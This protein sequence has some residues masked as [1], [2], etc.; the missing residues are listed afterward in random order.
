MRR[1]SRLRSRSVRA[2]GHEGRQLAP[3]ARELAL[4]LPER[5][6]TGSAH[7]GELD[8]GDAVADQPEQP[9][10]L[11]LVSPTILGHQA[12]SSIGSSWPSTI[13]SSSTS[14]GCDSMSAKER[15]LPAREI[16]A[17]T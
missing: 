10:D 11:A 1:L 17:R 5:G 3:C 8:L 9:L 12:A 15:T 4:L 7:P 6:A 14:A 16:A 13:A 2:G